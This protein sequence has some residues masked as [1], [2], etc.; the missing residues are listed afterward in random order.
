MHGYYN[1]FMVLHCKNQQLEQVK[2]SIADF[3]ASTPYCNLNNIT[4]K[5]N[6]YSESEDYKMIM[7]VNLCSSSDRMEV[8]NYIKEVLNTSLSMKMVCKEQ[9]KIGLFQYTLLVK[10]YEIPNMNEVD[11]YFKQYGRC[12]ISSNQNFVTYVNY[13]NFEDARSAYQST[14]LHGLKISNI[15]ARP[16]MMKFAR[17]LLE[18]EKD[19]LK[20]EDK[21]ISQQFLSYSYVEDFVNKYKSSS[22]FDMAKETDAKLEEACSRF[23]Q[24]FFD[25]RYNSEMCIFC[26]GQDD[27]TQD[28]NAWNACKNSDKVVA[29]GTGGQQSMLPT[30]IVQE[31]VL[32]NPVTMLEPIN[33]MIEPVVIAENPVRKSI[34][35]RMKDDLNALEAEL[36]GDMSDCN[37]SAKDR[38]AKIENFLDLASQG[39]DV[40][41]RLIQIK[42]KV[43]NLSTYYKDLEL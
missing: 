43:K 22:K 7:Y 20:I 34:F 15:V 2:A 39:L 33:K 28:E 25:W 35:E 29:E 24:K 19:L 17:M 32:A 18:L 8:I 5:T 26:S 42:N 9:G 11:S 23:V 13:Y 16:I 40:Q 36:F 4:T 12:E 37:V 1:S 3:C 41:Q 21:T 6:L 14:D 10:T 38:I 30:P 27:Y 31:I